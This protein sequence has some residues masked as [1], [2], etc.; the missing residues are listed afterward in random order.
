MKKKKL[1]KREKSKEKRKKL[2]SV[3][4]SIPFER[5]F[6]DGICR[7]RKGFYSKTIQFFDLN[8][9]LAQQEDQ[10][11]IFEEWCGILN[12]F[13]SSI[14]FEFSFLNKAID[15]CTGQDFL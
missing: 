9:R 5:M 15:I 2:K 12:Y 1:E 3:Q 10:K 7:V 13:D 4:D 14:A 6:L 8:Y 11:E